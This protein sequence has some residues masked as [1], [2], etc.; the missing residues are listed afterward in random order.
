HR[1]E[2]TRKTPHSLACSRS[3]TKT[4]HA[5]EI[6]ARQALRMDVP[7]ARTMHAAAQSMH[8]PKQSIDVRPTAEQP[9]QS[10]HVR[11]TTEQ[12]DRSAECARAQAP[13]MSRLPRE[14]RYRLLGG[15]PKLERAPAPLRA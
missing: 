10:M 6:G 1:A 8:A 7:P 3:G 11:R 4:R 15:V 9:A 14:R 12:P 5:K 2:S 13:S